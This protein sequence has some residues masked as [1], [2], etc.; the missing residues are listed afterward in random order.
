MNV[1][2]CK[3]YLSRR[4]GWKDLKEMK[5]KEVTNIVIYSFRHYYSL[6]GHILGVDYEN[7]AKSMGHSIEAQHRNYPYSSE[8]SVTNDLKQV[9]A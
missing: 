3:D 4:E 2:S 5:K 9:R 8:A 7:M 6:R 1:E